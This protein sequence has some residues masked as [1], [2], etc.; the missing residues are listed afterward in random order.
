MN[1][2]FKV[3]AT[4][5]LGTPGI[6]DADGFRRALM[7]KGILGCDSVYENDVLDD[8]P[9]TIAATPTELDLVAPTVAELGFSNVPD[10]RDIYKRAAEYRLLFCPFEAGP[11]FRLQYLQQ[12]MDERLIMVFQPIPGLSNFPLFDVGRDESG[13]YLR[14]YYRYP[15]NRHNLNDRFIF[16]QGRK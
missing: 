3:L 13:L 16:S 11:R 7:A 4:V 15:G 2:K 5:R 10:L 9:F 8:S 14:G 1:H 12:P 6:K